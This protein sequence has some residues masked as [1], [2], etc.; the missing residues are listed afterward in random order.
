MRN[1]L[2]THWTSSNRPSEAAW[3]LDTAPDRRLW[4]LYALWMVPLA[5]ILA[6]TGWLQLE[7]QADYV[8]PFLQTHE[9]LEPLPARDGRLL[10]ADGSILA[11]DAVSYD[12]LVHYRWLEDPVDVRWL[13]RKAWEQVSRSERRQPAVVQRAE[14]KVRQRRDE[15][16]H[17][18]SQILQI[19]P[20]EL[21]STNREIQI[22][23]EQIWQTVDRRRRQRS[24]TTPT[25]HDSDIAKEDGHWTDIVQH[26]WWQA[27]SELSSPPERRTDEP[28]VIQEQESYHLVVRDV[29]AEVAEEI[30][31]HPHRYPGVKIATRSH[32]I[33]PHGDLAAHLLGA[34][35]VLKSEDIPP[36]S[37]PTSQGRTGLERQYHDRLT[38]HAGQQRQVLNRH[39]EILLTEVVEPPQHGR[40][41]VLT[42]DLGLQRHAEQLLDA[43]LET[44]SR[45]G[46][47]VAPEAAA[48]TELPQGGVLVAVDV[49]T[50][51]VLTAAAAPRFD[52]NL[53]ITADQERWNRLAADPRKPFFPRVTHMALPPGSV[54]KAITA[55]ALQESGTFTPHDTIQCRGYL[56]QPDQ[57]R[58]LI[59]RHYNLG[60]GET[61]LSRALMQSCNVYFFTGAR[62]SG[63]EPLVQWS[64]QFGI[65][66]PTG[67]DLPSESSGTLPSKEPG[68]R[69]F[70][71]ETL[72]LA[73]GQGSLT[74]TPLQMA[75]AMAAIANGGFLVTP[76]LATNGG[77][78]SLDAEEMLTSRPVFAHPDPV[79]IPS[80]HPET[81]A[82]IREGLVRVVH[83]P[84]GTAYKTVRLDEVTIAGK[85]GTAE[86]GSGRGDH[87]WFAGFTPAENP[88]VA[89]VV[90]I[91]HGGSGSRTA[92]PIAREY[93]RH[94]LDSGL[95]SPTAAVAER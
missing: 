86:T 35:T 53:L 21:E 78:V 82:A 46:D 65:G 91:E 37:P 3:D 83:D 72:G 29:A 79:A 43:A 66:Q 19:D 42:I 34:R 68:R 89:F 58:C 40:D 59:F 20:V 88:R 54:F 52:A 71:G 80:L 32:R 12:L 60:H 8:A 63:A 41:V 64:Q 22:R 33:Y 48:P 38:G 55:V 87:A 81:L 92:G 49:H 23:V 50:G 11:D 9:L 44:V 6:R 28:L 5:L 13:K 15:L 62:R 47:D 27:V 24:Q 31:A 84:Q 56:D 70:A 10:A 61:D 93:V 94:L 39:G 7:R 16:W 18:L 75:R 85:T 74:V 36:N 26:L 51:A 45:T 73:I 90:V 4:L 95:I 57:Y 76:H 25:S 1:Q 69:W 17:D 2:H 77:A 14:A 30:T 67:I